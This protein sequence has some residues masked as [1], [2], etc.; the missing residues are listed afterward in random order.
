MYANFSLIHT[1]CKGHKRCINHQ[2]IIRL[3]TSFNLLEWYNSIVFNFFG[4]PCARLFSYSFVLSCLFL[5]LFF[6]ITYGYIIGI[7]PW[8]TRCAYARIYFRLGISEFSLY[9]RLLIIHSPS[10]H[11]PT[12]PKASLFMLTNEHLGCISDP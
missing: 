6:S 9:Q 10:P 7:F 4:K 5:F 1:L 2:P 12:T 11:V 8:I 3:L